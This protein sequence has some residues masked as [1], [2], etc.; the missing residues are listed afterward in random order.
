MPSRFGIIPRFGTADEVKWFEANPCYIYHTINCW[1]EGD[2]IVMDCCVNDNPTPQQELPPGAL[3]AEKL[4]A[5]ANL[6][7]LLISFPLFLM[8]CRDYNA[9]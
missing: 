7:R 6:L 5:D 2:E 8:V 9:C 1:E 4:N 3:P